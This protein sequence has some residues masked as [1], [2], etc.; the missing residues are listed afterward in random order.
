VVAEHPV[1]AAAPGGR[2][3][4]LLHCVGSAGDVLPFIAIGRHLLAGGA[5]VTL[6]T[7]AYFEPQARAAGVPFCAL[8]TP[9]DYRAALADP[10]LW[11][12]ARGISRLWA[13]VLH[14]V[15]PSLE[16]LAPWLED[17]DCLLVGSTLALAVRIAA[18]RG[19]SRTASV[20]LSPLCLLSAHDFP[21]LPGI[22]WVRGLPLAARRGALTLL[23]WQLDRIIAPGLN[24]LRAQYGLAPIR[25]VNRRW[26]HSPHAVI[27]AFP[28]WFAAAQP[29][30]PAQTEQCDFALPWSGEAEA[31]L[32][33]QR[34]QPAQAGPPGPAL[35]SGI[36]A[37]LAR[38]PAPVVFTAGTGMA[39]PERFLARAVE[40]A[41]RSGC[42]A[43]L[44]SALADRLPADLPVQ[45][46]AIR[47]AP[48]A[49]LLPRCA[50]IVHH[51]GIGTVASAL[52]AGIPQL[53]APFAYDQHDN[54]AR[55]ERL[56][57]GRRVSARSAGDWASA[58]RA[59]NGDS[60]ERAHAQ[61]YAARIAAGPS[62]AQRIARRLRALARGVSGADL[63]T[64]PG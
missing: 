40:A 42:R 37:F 58:L 12:P 8:G 3:R 32:E 24:A 29:D 33:A 49:C 7:S 1:A 48:F 17:P 39:Q 22:G 46:M 52:A 63:A 45:V 4:V 60:A 64:K 11:D 10:L 62:G 47:D 50:A 28:D 27:A 51:G 56:G 19:H 36:E 13:R 53:I 9:E 18:E 14:S 57:A 59:V 23:D 16:A 5:E 54:A 55:I 30:W 31:P 21:R 2:P 43:L 15:P 34:P 6:A 25:Q 35:A 44:V 38:G 61:R 41:Q 26:L 20:H